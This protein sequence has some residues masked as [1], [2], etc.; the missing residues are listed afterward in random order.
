MKTPVLVVIL[1]IQLSGCGGDTTPTGLRHAPSGQPISR[2]LQFGIDITSFTYDGDQFTALI[3]VHN[4]SDVGILVHIDP[5]KAP[6]YDD[7]VD[8]G[9]LT[10]PDQTFLRYEK[11]VEINDFRPDAPSG[12]ALRLIPV[13]GYT[14]FNV[15]GRF[16]SVDGSPPTAVRIRGVCLTDAAGANQICAPTKVLMVE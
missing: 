5:L 2:A 4:G 3:A 11:S 7:A 8:V 12:K 14:M 13:Q 1:A 15:T 9:T 16:T 6:Q 10:Q